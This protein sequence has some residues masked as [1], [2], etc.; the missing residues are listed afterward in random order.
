MPDPA[1]LARDARRLARDG[2]T[3][4]AF[5]A[6]AGLGEIADS[7]VAEDVAWVLFYVLRQG[8][9][10]GVWPTPENPK[11][12]LMRYLALPVARPSLVHSMMLGAAWRLADVDPVFNTLSFFRLWGGKEAFRPEDY[13]ANDPYPSLVAQSVRR[14]VRSLF[15]N[16]WHD[17]RPLFDE[18][19]LP[20]T[21]LRSLFYEAFAANLKWH[22]RMRPI[23][24]WGCLR[25][26]IDGIHAEAP[27]PLRSEALRVAIDSLRSDT[28]PDPHSWFP[29][30]ILNWNL[31][32][33]APEDFLP[34]DGKPSLMQ[35]AVVKIYES[36][37][38]IIP[39]NPAFASYLPQCIAVV[40]EV[41]LLLGSR[42]WNA[43]RLARMLHWAGRN[44]ESRE[45]LIAAHNGL[46][47]RACYWL[48]LGEA[49]S[50]AD[51]R[52]GCY[53]MCLRL[54]PD[55]EASAQYHLALCRALFDA[56]RSEE[57][58]ESIAQIQRIYEL[59]R[60][61]LPDDILTMAHRLVPPVPAA[62]RPQPAD[63]PPFASLTAPL[64]N[65]FPNFK[66]FITDLR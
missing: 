48:A 31:R 18:A 8:L 64:S 49:L 38:R 33:A 37:R 42:D 34:R 21:E 32:Q 19:L 62:R 26:Y 2:D 50:D 22:E 55:G 47:S 40:Q 60:H 29:W 11:R 43:Y 3:V 54:Q 23:A 27:A 17:L 41:I 10:R 13:Q 5:R 44:D 39:Q 45:L 12:H 14:L 61:I 16:N 20:D 53:A 15:Y 6:I 4:S 58:R 57:A 51:L 28:S 65:L 25:K 30:F 56:K 66:T 59:H 36:F 63:F 7:A 1:A 35:Q 46:K 9:Q 52:I 24:I